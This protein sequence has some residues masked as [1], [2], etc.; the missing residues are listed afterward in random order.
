MRPAVVHRIAVLAIIAGMIGLGLI[1]GAVAHSI[2]EYAC[3]ADHDCG[4]VAF[5]AVQAT[6]DGYR[7]TFATGRVE[8]LSY[9][10]TRIRPTPPEDVEQR[11]HVC[12]VGG[13]PDGFLLCLY[14]PQGGS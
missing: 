4:P 11:Y 1:Y 12:T 7:V 10:D 3:C 2:Y 9:A 5:E 8:V 14:V 13:S 6:P